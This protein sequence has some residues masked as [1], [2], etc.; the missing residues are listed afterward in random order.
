MTVNPVVWMKMQLELIVV[1]LVELVV[2]M[3][4]QMESIVTVN[5]VV[6]METQ[7][8]LIE[9][10][11]VEKKQIEELVVLTLVMVLVLECLVAKFHWLVPAV[12][13]DLHQPW[14]GS[15]E[16]DLEESHH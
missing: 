16:M 9:I 6:W 3:D 2:G 10:V 8:E 7:L 4:I 15:L 12:V 14:P 11:L 5:P 1:V 13:Q